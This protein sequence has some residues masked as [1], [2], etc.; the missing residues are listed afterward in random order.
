MTNNIIYLCSFPNGKC[1]VG[2]TKNFLKRK[3]VHECTA[4]REK[5]HV[6][7]TKFYRAIRKYGIENLN[8]KILYENVSSNQI[9]LAEICSIYLYNSYYDGYNMTMGGEG[10]INP[11]HETRKKIS[12][13]QIGRTA[14]NKGKK[15]LQVSVNKGKKLTLEQRRI[16][17]EKTKEA[18]WRPDV[19]ENYEK[20]MKNVKPLSGESHPRPHLGKSRSEEVKKKISETM[21]RKGLNPQI[22]R[23]V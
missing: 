5:S 10:L 11:S 6:Y 13:S 16:I 9:D 17:S 22:W 8:W 15:G 20:A 18:I 1:Y 21:K 12:N 19:R 4:F 23:A 14:W 3:K 7:N 2:K